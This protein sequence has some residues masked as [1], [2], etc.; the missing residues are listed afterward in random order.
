M[1]FI[2]IRAILCYYNN[3]ETATVINGSPLCLYANI[4]IE[5]VSGKIENLLI[6]FSTLCAKVWNHVL[7]QWYYI[8]THVYYI[9]IIFIH[10]YSQMS[11]KEGVSGLG[12]LLQGGFPTTTTT[13]DG[14]A[15]I[16]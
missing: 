7:L 15:L 14:F 4:K 2:Y 16:G 11:L 6:S 8:H 3:N 10:T 9:C 13:T 12:R 1:N 5:K